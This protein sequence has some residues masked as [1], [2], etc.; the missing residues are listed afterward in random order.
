M[1]GL[2]RIVRGGASCRRHGLRVNTMEGAP[3][4]S[5]NEA[6]DGETLLQIV[7]LVI[8]GVAQGCIYGLIAL[9]FVL[10]YKA[11]ETVSCA[12]GDLMMVGAFC[13]FAG[14][15]LFGLPFWLAALLAVVAMVALGVLLELV[16]IRPVLAQPQF[17][18]VM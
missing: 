1:C 18:I 17:S 13:A 16:I 3:R 5:Y 10:I 4:A 2:H 14:M 6:K 9:G 12:Q 7:Q 8:S 11:T 15:S